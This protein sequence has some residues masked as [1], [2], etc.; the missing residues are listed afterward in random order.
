MFCVLYIYH[1][2]SIQF[3]SFLFMVS[4]SA[5]GLVENVLLMMI[6]GCISVTVLMEHVDGIVNNAV[7]CLTMF[8]TPDME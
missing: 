1:F 2:S 8:H 6:L 4:V 5:M 3:L 7:Q